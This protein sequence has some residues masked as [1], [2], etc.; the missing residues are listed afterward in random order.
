MNFIKMSSLVKLAQV[1]KKNVR[2][3]QLVQRQISTSKK[4]QEVCIT[5][6]AINEEE[7]VIFFNKYYG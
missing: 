1:S 6:T 4:N 5:N 7:P 3:F 2:L